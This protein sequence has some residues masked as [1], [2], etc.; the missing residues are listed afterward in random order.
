MIEKINSVPKLHK[1]WWITLLVG[2]ISLAISANILHGFLQGDDEALFMTRASQILYE[3]RH[4]DMND[5]RFL[6]LGHDHPPAPIIILSFFIAI[7]GYN[8]IALRLPNIILWVA[9]S[10]VATRVGWR[11]G[12][13]TVG[14]LSGFFIAIS[15]IY[16]IEALGFGMSFEV[17]GVLLLINVLLDHFE[18]NLN[19]P[20]ARYKYWLG[21]AYLAIGYL[22]YTSTL[23]IIGVYHALF[24]FMA[25]K[26]NPKFET[27][28]S[29]LLYTLPF[30]GF[31]L[32]YNLVFLGIPAYDVYA[33]GVAPYGQLAQNLGRANTALNFDSFIFNIKV[34]NWFILPFVSWFILG[35]GMWYQ[36]RNNILIFITLLG[37]FLIWSFYLG[38]NTGQHFLAYFCWV[39][40][41]GIMAIYEFVKKREIFWRICTWILLFSMILAWTYTTHIKMYTYESYPRSLISLFWAEPLGWINNIYRPMNEIAKVLDSKLGPN[42]KY[43]SLID[44]SFYR[45][46]YPEP[47]GSRYL[48]VE[49]AMPETRKN[50]DGFP[51]LWMSWDTIKANKIR[52][53][54]SYTNQSV[55]SELIGEVIN[56]PGSN[57]KLTLIR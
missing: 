8:V 56:Y 7:L 32:L 5:V 38:G 27:I 53:V 20:S 48:P 15:A 35:T 55:C 29:Y 17:L 43:L 44:T 10:M 22:F 9:V 41:F 13:L 21:G 33:H 47:E 26:S 31:Y 46:Y 34:M 52:A 50:P 40:P 14:F 4:G 45:F 12:G 1:I 3:F 30:I 49:S 19:S 23:P 25:Y 36:F 39:L 18:W 54:V 11:V 28:K 6:I 42:S 16:D 2:I 24:A 37:Y 51:C 57:L